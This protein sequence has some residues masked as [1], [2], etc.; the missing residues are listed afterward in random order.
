MTTINGAASVDGL[1]VHRLRPSHVL[2]FL[3]LVAS[4]EIVD[5]LDLPLPTFGA[6]GVELTLVNLSCAG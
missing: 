5:S 2:D 1:P 4:E 6:E 3:A